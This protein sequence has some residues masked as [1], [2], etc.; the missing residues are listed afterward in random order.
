MINNSPVPLLWFPVDTELIFEEAFSSKAAAFGGAN[1]RV[2]I[3]DL[4]QLKFQETV[5]T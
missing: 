5:I 1:G 2:I 4:T 3:L